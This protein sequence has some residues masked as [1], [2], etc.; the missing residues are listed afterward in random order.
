M[1]RNLIWSAFVQ[2]KYG[3]EYL[4]L[5][6]NRQRLIYKSFKIITI[7]LSASGIWTAVNE[8]KIPTIIS[9]TVIGLM[10]IV[11]SIEGYLI[12][13]EKEIDKL[14][15]LRNMYHIHTNEF[16]EL[17]LKVD[18]L[19]ENELKKCFFELRQKSQKIEALDNKS[20]I[21]KW[22]GLMKEAD[23]STINYLKIYNS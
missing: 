20:H 14:C 4:I 22:K 23:I 15:E 13:T 3:D 17:W 16:E 8:W 2:A 9:C 12:N 7:V 19:E 5:Y 10:Q 6:I 18:D 21:K 1:V 11:T